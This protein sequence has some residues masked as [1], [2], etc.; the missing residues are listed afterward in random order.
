MQRRHLFVLGLRVIISVALTLGL[1]FAL[2][3][4]ESTNRIAGWVATAAV[5]AG[6]T[7]LIWSWWHGSDRLRS[8]AL[9]GVTLGCAVAAAEVLRV[10]VGAGGAG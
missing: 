7:W 9:I 8:A 2:A 4:L 10:L 1:S 6:M 3:W 5:V